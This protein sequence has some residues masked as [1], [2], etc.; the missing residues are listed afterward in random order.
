MNISEGNGSGDVVDSG[1][2]KGKGRKRAST[3]AVANAVIDFLVE[4]AKS[5]RSRCRGCEETIVKGEVRISKKDYESEE[6]KKFDGIDLWHHTSC[7][8]K[9]RTELGFYLS[10]DSLPGA[11]SLSPEDQKLLKTLLPKLRE[12]EVPPVKKIKNEPED[13]EEEAK[14]QKQNKKMFKIRD[15]L[16]KLTK[17]ILT[18]L[19][20]ENEQFVPEGAPEVIVFIIDFIQPNIY[21]TFI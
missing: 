18:E 8:A 19:L 16:S 20:V 2:S 3:A 6:A 7:F 1:K 14:M 15:S 4:Y 21:F 17:P 10:G 12:S 5:N 9:L 11:K 13:A